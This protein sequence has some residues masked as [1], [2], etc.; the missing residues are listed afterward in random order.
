MREI[1]EALEPYIRSRSETAAVRTNISAALLREHSG[2]LN[3]IS[4]L[5]PDTNT[6]DYLRNKST[7]VRKAYAKALEAH[8]VAQER[9][10][11]LRN[12]IH[13]IKLQSSLEDQSSS[14]VSNDRPAAEAI[15]ASLRDRKR[16]ERLQIVSDALEALQ[17]D[18]KRVLAS[19]DELAGGSSSDPTLPE[20]LLLRSDHLEPPDEALQQLKKEIIRARGQRH[21]SAT[22]PL[23]SAFTNQK[24]ENQT[25][26][27]KHA[28][29]QARD[30]LIMLIEVEL[31]KIP[32]EDPSPDERH[33][34]TDDRLDGNGSPSLLELDSTQRL[35][36]RYVAARER[37]VLVLSQ[38]EPNDSEHSDQDRLAAVVSTLGTAIGKPSLSLQL[39]PHIAGLR[40][41]S[42]AEDALLQEASYSRQQL[43]GSSES[44][45]R[46]L[47]RLADES[48]MVA[49][50]SSK[51]IAWT[52]A[53][54]EARDQDATFV[55]ARLQAGNRSLDRARETIA[56]L[57]TLG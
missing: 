6:D 12:D 30:E 26:S 13:A 57:A 19:T 2:A 25:R 53:A 23:P 34:D 49:P 56:G 39:L 9:L 28:L 14:D 8:R 41:A 45:R 46:T 48:L 4:L 43:A 29:Q 37:L 40:A 15:V 33:V 24:S 21:A 7:G 5:N 51:A 42:E 44:I 52:E 20:P 18:R 27:R 31:A 17:T 54:A 32:S 38:A 47:R 3:S 1:G 55:S 36:D 10:D 16:Y 35:Y 22:Q 50:G 11:R